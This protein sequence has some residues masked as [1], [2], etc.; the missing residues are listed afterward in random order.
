MKASEN[1]PKRVRELRQRF[2]MTQAELAKRAC[3]TQQAVVLWEHGRAVPQGGSVKRLAK[4]FSVPADDL[5]GLDKGRY[6]NLEKR[7]E[8]LEK[9]VKGLAR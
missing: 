5:L 9:I 8:R 7:V 4:I 3:V 1:F 6:A 2:G